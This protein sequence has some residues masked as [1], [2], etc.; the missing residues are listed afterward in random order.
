MQE[1]HMVVAEEI[2]QALAQAGTDPNEVMSC[3]TYLN[4]PDQRH[5]FFAYLDAVIVDG[6]AVV[7]SGRTLAYYRDIRDVCRR[8]LA[9]YSDEPQLMAEI[10]G[11]AA[12]LMR[13]YAVAHSPRATRPAPG[14]VSQRRGTQ[15]ETARPV[16]RGDRQSGKVK[17]FS[18]D[19]HFGF[20]TPEGGGKDVFFHEKG[21]AEGNPLRPNQRV[22]YTVSQGQK[23]PQASDVRPV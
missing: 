18:V 7:R 8:Y 11:W 1:N 6:R 2:A 9:G 23:G 13:F 15:R 4:N 20:I 21:V 14:P 17:F 12:R 10:L 22:T 16:T 3:V 19:R 5:S